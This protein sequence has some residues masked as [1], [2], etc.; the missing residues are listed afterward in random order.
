VLLDKVKGICKM[1]LLDRVEGK[2]EITLPDM[3]KYWDKLAK[4]W[5]KLYL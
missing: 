2:Y 3:A 5:G 4:Y 1:G